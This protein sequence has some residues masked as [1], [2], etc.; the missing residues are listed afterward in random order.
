[1]IQVYTICFKCKSSFQL[2]IVCVIAGQGLVFIKSLA[3]VDVRGD[4]V[5][6]FF[7]AVPGWGEPF[8]G[9]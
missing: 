7:M 8:F 6:S 2:G 3:R 1:M 9:M 4:E 5:Q